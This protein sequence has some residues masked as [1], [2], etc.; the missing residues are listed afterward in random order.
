MSLTR[1]TWKRISEVGYHCR[2]LWSFKLLPI[3]LYHRSCSCWHCILI[4]T[5]TFI[6]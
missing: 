3:I 2:M 1:R 4:E 5:N 6:I